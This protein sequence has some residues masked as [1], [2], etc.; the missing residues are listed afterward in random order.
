MLSGNAVRQ[1]STWRSR[2]GCCQMYSEYDSPPTRARAEHDQREGPQQIELLLDRERPQV[3]DVPR[4]DRDEVRRV[5]R[6]DRE[7]AAGEIDPADRREQ[8]GDEKIRVERGEDPQRP[9]QVEAA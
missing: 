2:N 4:P 6:G 3:A 1:L 5:R 7:I 8:R 9:A